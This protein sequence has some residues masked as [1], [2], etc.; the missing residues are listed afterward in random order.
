MAYADQDHGHHEGPDAFIWKYVWS[1][2]HK[3]IAVQYGCTAILVG[4][5][6]LVLSWL[7]FQNFCRPPSG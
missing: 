5:L 4:L 3:V 2:D 1:Q 6:A 7:M